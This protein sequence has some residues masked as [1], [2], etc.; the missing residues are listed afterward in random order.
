VVILV[1]ESPDL[2]IEKDMEDLIATYPDDFFPRRHFVLIGRQ[3]SFAGIGRFDLVFEDEFKSTILMEMKAR[4]LKYEDATQVAKYRDELE[5]NG[6][7]NIV[8]WLVAPQIPSSVREFLDDK[9]I[10]YSEIHVPEFRLIAER[11]DFM[12]KS[13][14]EPQ[15]ASVSAAS[16]GSAGSFVAPQLPKRTRLP[17]SVVPTGPVVTSHPA[18]CWRAVGYDLV[19]DN[20]ESSMPGSSSAWWTALKRPYAM[21]RI[22]HS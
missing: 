4:T 10:E 6:C 20:P 2:M 7:S 1:P 11:R 14:V 3:R 19:L 9:G 8:M 15:K 16:I 5:R 13:E 22:G 17:S 12:I 18:L 21:A